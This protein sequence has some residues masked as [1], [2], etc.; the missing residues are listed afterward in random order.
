MQLWPI[1]F[2]DSKGVK[3]KTEMKSTVNPGF[4][5]APEYRAQFLF[6]DAAEAIN[7]GIFSYIGPEMI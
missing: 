3:T 4:T 2:C 5:S 1:L 6:R 7:A